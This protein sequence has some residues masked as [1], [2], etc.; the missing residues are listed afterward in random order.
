MH[1]FLNMKT[2]NNGINIRWHSRPFKINHKL[3][4]VD[5]ATN[6][7]DNLALIIHAA[8]Y[9]LVKENSTLFVVLK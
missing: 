3:C 8:K 4:V 5:S 7:N 9:Y 1:T 2:A 6:T